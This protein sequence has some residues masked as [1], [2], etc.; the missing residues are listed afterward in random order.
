M[1]NEAACDAAE[2]TLIANKVDENRIYIFD[3]LE[4][5]MVALPEAHAWK[6]KSLPPFVKGSMAGA[7]AGSMAALAALLVPPAGVPIDWRQAVFMIV[8]G[9]IMGSV[10]IGMAAHGEHAKRLKKFEDAMREDEWLL[11]VDVPPGEEKR[12]RNLVLTRHA[13]KYLGTVPLGKLDKNK[14]TTKKLDKK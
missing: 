2:T 9:T 8:V 14:P 1:D 11:V 13:A 4:D 12:L 7:I 5:E 10:M 3:N 6:R